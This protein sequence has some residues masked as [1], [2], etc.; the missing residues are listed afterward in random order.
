MK[1]N[2]IDEIPNIHEGQK[3]KAD[4]NKDEYV[5][6]CFAPYAKRYPNEFD[7]FQ[8]IEIKKGFESGLTPEQVKIYAEPS[9]DYHQMIAIRAGLE[10]GLTQEQVK[11][12]AD[13]LFSHFQM[14][15]IIDGFVH[16]LTPEQVKVYANPLFSSK[17]MFQIADGMI[18]YHLSKEQVQT[19]ARPLFKPEYMNDI[20]VGLYT[21]LTPEQ[22]FKHADFLAKWRDISIES[23]ELPTIRL[24][25]LRWCN[26][27]TLY[28]VFN[29]QPFADAWKQKLQ[30]KLTSKKGCAEIFRCLKPFLAEYQVFRDNLV[31]SIQK[32]S[33]SDQISDAS[34][35][36]K[37]QNE[38]KANTNINQ[39]KQTV[40][41]EE[42]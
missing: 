28:D 12:C 39:F 5:V 2:K 35:K 6:K 25:D 4:F 27:S 24:N 38:N 14:H 19:Y 42:R 8:I 22:A 32:Q 16:G 23:L 11:I 17:Q 1:D 34:I 37:S 18:D 40:S 9:F 29:G 7:L 13:P 26:Y 41:Q 31:K 36:Q 3:T 10:F 20:K 15:E 30:Y 21:G 33:L